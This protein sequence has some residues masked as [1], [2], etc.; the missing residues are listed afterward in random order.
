MP[1]CAESAYSHALFSELTRT[2]RVEYFFAP[3]QRH[4][5][6][7]GYDLYTR[8]E[9]EHFFFQF[10]VPTEPRKPDP[11][12]HPYRFN[13][14][15]QQHAK[16]RRINNISV[17]YVAPV[18]SQVRELTQCFIGGTLQDNSM[19]LPV[20]GFPNLDYTSHHVTYDSRSALVHS[21]P[22]EI[23]GILLSGLLE[24]PGLSRPEN[25]RPVNFIRSLL[26]DLLANEVEKGDWP[27]VLSSDS[28]VE[29]AFGLMT[30]LDSLQ[31]TMLTVLRNREPADR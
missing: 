27:E 4:E 21:E 20:S 8:I 7:V 24:Q 15:M 3:T 29:L 11:A 25:V 13:L 12:H 19:T 17:Y 14:T 6:R 9:A 22:Q 10:K 2:Y 16:L 1:R 26:R 23:K 18:F 31:L 28:A 30:A 5:K